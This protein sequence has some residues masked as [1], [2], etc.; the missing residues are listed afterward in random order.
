MTRNKTEPEDNEPAPEPPDYE[1]LARQ[2][3]DLWQDQ[4]AAMAA[5]PG[6]METLSKMTAAWREAMYSFLQGTGAGAPFGDF[7]AI[8]GTGGA[9]DDADRNSKD[10]DR[11]AAAGAKA[12]D[13]AP[14]RSDVDVDALL[15]RIA[16]LE[17]RLAALERKA[18]GK[19]KPKRKAGAGKPAKKS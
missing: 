7:A 2:Y 9:S 16:D 12:S 8:P 13:G 18:G 15:H 5:D 14:G 10:N 17:T 11:A 19:A 6:T 3:L 1:A 4:F